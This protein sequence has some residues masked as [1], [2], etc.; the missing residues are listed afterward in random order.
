MVSDKEEEDEAEDSLS[1]TDDLDDESENDD[2]KLQSSVTKLKGN[3]ESTEKQA[4]SSPNSQLTDTKE[5]ASSLSSRFK[6]LHALDWFRLGILS[7]G[8]FYAMCWCGSLAH[9]AFTRA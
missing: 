4:C 1:D 6:Q 5:D 7:T 9:L 3:D 8:V 2:K